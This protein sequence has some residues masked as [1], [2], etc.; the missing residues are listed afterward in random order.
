LGN[1]PVSPRA[2]LGQEGTIFWNTGDEHDELGHI[3]EDPGLRNAMM[4]KRFAKLDLA[5]KEIP[6]DVKLK[7][8][9]P[10]D[11]STV[12]VSWG[13]TKGALLDALDRLWADGAKIGYLHV[14]LIKPFPVAEVTKFL[15]KAKR[16]IGVEMNFGGQLASVVRE[17]TGIQMTHLVL[18][19]NG[20]PMSN[21]ELY[22]ALGP[23]LH[24]KAEKRTVLTR[25]A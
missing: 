7:Y 4:E 2:L 12:I 21:T 15:A 10:K 13:S 23:I 6:A 24:G 17:Q 18:K 20:R 22:D 25:G 14:R 1:G 3:T 9:G 16:R 8:F 5:A 11:A 19:Y